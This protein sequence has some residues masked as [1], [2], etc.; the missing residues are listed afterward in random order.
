MIDNAVTIEEDYDPSRE[1]HRAAKEE[2]GFWGRR[3]AGCLFLSNQ[4]E[5]ILFAHR[6]DEVLEPNTWGTW[7]GACPWIN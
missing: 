1:Q 7:G 3:G 2:T 6:S 5:R 4:T